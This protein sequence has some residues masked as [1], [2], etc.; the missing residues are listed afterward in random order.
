MTLKRL[1]LRFFDIKGFFTG[2]KGIIEF[3]K[4]RIGSITSIEEGIEGSK[5]V[6]KDRIEPITSI[7]ASEVF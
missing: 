7:K 1:L 4:N 3:L 6:L 5:R 2:Y